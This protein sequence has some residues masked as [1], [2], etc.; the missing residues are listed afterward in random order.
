[1]DDEHKLSFDKKN[2]MRMHIENMLETNAELECLAFDD[3][4]NETV[5]QCRPVRMSKSFSDITYKLERDSIKHFD[6]KM[7]SLYRSKLW[8]IK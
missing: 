7:W 1:M 6:E 2:L 4:Y 5:G 8:Q 3:G